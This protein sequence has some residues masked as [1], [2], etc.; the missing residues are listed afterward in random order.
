MIA[1]EKTGKEFRPV[2]IGEIIKRVIAKVVA[3]AI[4]DEVKEVTG[5]R[6]CSGLE[7]AC[8]AAV[9]AMDQMY[10]EGKVVIVLDAENAY[11]NL[12]LNGALKTAARELPEA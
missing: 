8:E 4:R 10:K 12:D 7:G 5:S 2:G 6:Q 1:I 11:N 3:R 9:K